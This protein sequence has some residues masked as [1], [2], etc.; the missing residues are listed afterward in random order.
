MERTHQS[1]AALARYFEEKLDLALF[2]KDTDLANGGLCV[3]HS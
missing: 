1:F 3:G 2:A